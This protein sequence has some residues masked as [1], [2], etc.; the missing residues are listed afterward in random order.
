MGRRLSAHGEAH[1]GLAGEEDFGVFADEVDGALEVGLDIGGGLGGGAVVFPK[2]LVGEVLAD[3]FAFDAE[4]KA[5]QADTGVER[6]AVGTVGGDF[7]IDLDVIADALE[8]PAKVALERLLE[9]TA[10]DDVVGFAGEVELGAEAC[11]VAD[12]I[13]FGFECQGELILAGFA[14]LLG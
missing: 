14:D 1:L 3:G 2:G 4:A 6:D 13:G 9:G 7:G 5:H 12:G 8:R 11:V 10:L